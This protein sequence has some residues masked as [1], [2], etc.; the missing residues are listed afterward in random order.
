VLFTFS[1][2]GS[3]QGLGRIALQTAQIRDDN[4]EPPPHGL[5]HSPQSPAEHTSWPPDCYDV[6]T[7]PFRGSLLDAAGVMGDSVPEGTTGWC[8][9]LYSFSAVIPAFWFK[10]N[11][12][13][14]IYKWAV[15]C[16]SS[17]DPYLTCEM[18]LRGMQP[19]GTPG[20]PSTL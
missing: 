14:S 18:G 15:T 12:T 6:K 2:L 11:V 19:K 9:T 10:L 16:T 13:L 5:G 8:L 20:Q 7:S 4:G 1:A 17:N 3:T